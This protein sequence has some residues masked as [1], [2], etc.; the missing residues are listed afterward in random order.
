M[1][2]RGH[3]L[4]NIVATSLSLLAITAILVS[5]R[6]VS[7]QQTPVLR[8]RAEQASVKVDDTVT[9]Y[10]EVVDVANLYGYELVLN[11][12][13]N[14]IAFEDGD[15]KKSGVN[16]QMGDFLSPDFVVLNSV[17]AAAG[18]ANLAV[19][20]LSPSQ[21]VTGTGALAQ[22]TLRG[23]TQG[24]V[25][26]A[27]SDVVLSDPAGVA[28]PVTL[29]GCSVEV[30]AANSTPTAT[31]TPT[32]SVTPPTPTATATATATRTPGEGGR[33]EGAIFEDIN[34][35][36]IREPTE[37]GVYA[38]VKLYEVSR[39][40]NSFHDAVLSDPDD[41]SYAFTDLAD[42]R[43]VLEVTPMERT[44]YVY[45]TLATVDVNIVGA[46]GFS[47]A[48]FGLLFSD[49]GWWIYLPSVISEATARR[50]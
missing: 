45:T 25:D 33:I 17:D 15:P 27:F 14:R 47:G 31:P 42:G 11:F 46:T 30:I 21:P 13:S 48:D 16:L 12:N 22:A 38:L 34:A 3:V 39:Q 24:S 2:H 10:V 7:A 35:N 49:S 43:Y 29:Q 23:L 32:V 44:D 28:I 6:Y 41:G 40:T 9:F 19:T 37:P 36:T 20:Q 8:C 4:R 18:K 5:G 26:F 50:Q 1:L